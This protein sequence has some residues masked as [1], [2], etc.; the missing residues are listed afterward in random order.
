M[1]GEP[2]RRMIWQSQNRQSVKCFPVQGMNASGAICWG[3]LTSDCGNGH[4]QIKSSDDMRAATDGDE[5]HKQRADEC[6]LGR[7][8]KRVSQEEVQQLQ[9]DCA[10]SN[11]N[12]EIKS[13][14]H[15]LRVPPVP[16]QEG[17]RD[18]KVEAS[19]TGLLCSPCP[20]AGRRDHWN[21]TKRLGSISCPEIFLKAIQLSSK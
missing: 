9:R 12:Q 14:Q 15:L 16:A 18:Q 7:D 3:S 1:C 21:C 11:C 6:L 5:G 17:D 13:Q 2:V 4:L 19:G 8:G 20:C 10:I